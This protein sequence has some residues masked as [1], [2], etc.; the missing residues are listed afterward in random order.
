MK[1]M[2]K[3]KLIEEFKTLLRQK[4][5]LSEVEFRLSLEQ[6]IRN[7]G[8]IGI[9]LLESLLNSKALDT[10][11]RL[12]LI[13][14][15]G[16]INMPRLLIPLKRIIEVDENIHLK[17]EAVISVAKFND[18]KALNILN[19]AITT[20]KNP[21][22]LQTVNVE[23]AKIKQNNPILALL[24][25]FLQG[26]GNPKAFGVTLSILKRIINAS[27]ASA[28]IT[29]LN[30]GRSDLEN[31]A[32]EIICAGGSQD[33][34]HFI[35]EF[36]A[37]K[38]SSIPA[39]DAAEC[40][41]IYFL[42]YHLNVYLFRC[43]EKTAI[44]IP[45]LQSILARVGDERVQ[46]I[47]IAMLGKGAANA[48]DLHYLAE[49]FMARP[50]LQETLIES[51]QGNPTAVPFLFDLYRQA[52][53]NREAVIS[54][55]LCSPEGCD[56][57]F[58]AFDELEFTDQQ[59]VINHLPGK[60]SKELNLFINHVFQKGAY[61]LKE[62]LMQRVRSNFD[63]S[64]AAILFDPEH[65][66]EFTFMGEVYLE[67]IRSLFPIQ[68]I[69]RTVYNLYTEE[70]SVSQIKRT[71]HGLQPLIG[72]ELFVSFDPPSLLGA[73]LTKILAFSSKDLTLQ[74]LN[75]FRSLRSFDPA[76][77]QNCLDALS[78]VY[79]MK[80]SKTSPQERSEINRCRDWWRDNL[81][82]LREIEDGKNKLQ[83]VLDQRPFSA[84]SF[85]EVWK[86]AQ[87]SALMMIEEV[88][89]KLRTLFA[90]TVEGGI[91]DW[92]QLFSSH[93]PLAI[94][95]NEEIAR[96]LARHS[97]IIYNPL[98]KLH[99]ELPKSPPIVNVQTG[100]PSQR[101]ILME[102]LMYAMP[103]MTI[104]SDEIELRKQ[105]VLLCD[106]E[107]LRARMLLGKLIPGQLYLFLNKPAEILPFKD[108]NPRSL[109]APYSY[110]RIT[111]EILS[112]LLL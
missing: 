3:E 20:I 68:T 74:F 38:W 90:E 85:A 40:E 55:L 27:E 15:S 102:S 52:S 67:T 17:K 21:L 2:D 45:V 11:I 18:Q 110:Y 29:Y 34:S 87:V 65:E 31:G 16:Y 99:N 5:S 46:R 93:Q 30:C 71:L 19:H 25:R 35:R 108:L 10:T 23:I 104:S 88:F 103:L 9:D 101:A 73:L 6:L 79:T 72:L 82:D 60:K 57:F 70:Y 91:N 105:D 69:R 56:F 92:T 96:L 80:D 13:R 14:V 100:S 95:M 94:Y 33:H 112:H 62:I 53:A 28:F 32:Y 75:L 111:K 39:V 59:H 109:I 76:T 8:E 37:K 48:D 49:Y 97:E 98:R 47:I 26:N 77:A 36:I 107:A 1:P 4:D 63:P 7:S 50:A 61:R 24:P 64:V 54:S 78:R 44:F 81:L 58:N 84:A 22:L 51:L 43:P 12:Q 42:A 83:R 41:E 66:K 106:A 86:N 89:E